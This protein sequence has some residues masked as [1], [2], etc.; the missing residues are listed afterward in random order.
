M[1][2]K[3]RE[4]KLIALA[5]KMPRYDD[6]IIEQYRKNPEYAIERVQDEFQEYVETDDIRYLLST[7]REVAEAK[8]WS[9]LSRETGLSRSVLYGALSGER[10]PQISTVM[11]ILKALGVHVFTN[12][13]P[14]K[15]KKKPPS[16]ESGRRKHK[17]AASIS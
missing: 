1:D 8:G 14:L 16:H 6:F 13:A 9:V 4:K 3:T 2:D 10:D 5:L 17:E 11:K 7:L 15:S 12:I